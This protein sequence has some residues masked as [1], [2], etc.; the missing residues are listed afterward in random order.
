MKNISKSLVLVKLRLLG[1][2]LGLGFVARK[3]CLIEPS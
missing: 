3:L 1:G 2:G